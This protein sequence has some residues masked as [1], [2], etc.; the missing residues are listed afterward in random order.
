LPRPR[1]PSKIS[2]SFLPKE[3][4]MVLL[5]RADKAP[6]VKSGDVRQGNR[7]VIN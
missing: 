3:S 7:K 6:K 1:R 5:Y 2:W 4:N